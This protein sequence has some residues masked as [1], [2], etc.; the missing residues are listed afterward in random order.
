MTMLECVAKAEGIVTVLLHDSVTQSM[1]LQA[2]AAALLAFV[3]DLRQKETPQLPM[4][5][6][7]L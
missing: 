2:V 1:A 4:R 3:V 7:D 5:R 6:P